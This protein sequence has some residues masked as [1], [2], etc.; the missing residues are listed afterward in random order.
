MAQSNLITRRDLL[1]HG[2]GSDFVGYFA[3][4]PVEV[5]IDTAGALGVMTVKWRP[6]GAEDW[7]QPAQLSDPG[8]SWTWEIP[9]P[10]WASVT[11]PADDYV[12][13][14]A[15]IIDAA[16]TVTPVSTA[17]DTLTGERFDIITTICAG[18]TS[19]IVT[20]AATR[21]VLPVVSIGEGSKGWGAVIAIYR[22][23]SRQGMTPS[24]AG[25]GDENLR[26]RA[27]DAELNFKAIGRAD[28]RPPDFVDSSTS[29]AG[30]GIP[31]LP[32]SRSPRGFGTL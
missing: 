12:A 15:W 20:W 10:S 25:S 26:A 29:G 31:Q 16:G 21:C 4:A 8:S 18:V 3:L 11:F 32:V 2:A 9:D 5:A 28:T 17:P 24:G 13:D 7:N 19:D 14:D 27:L 6:V 1:N 22:L 23:K 30:T